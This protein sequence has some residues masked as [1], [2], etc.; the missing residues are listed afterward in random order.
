MFN[1]QKSTKKL[2][3]PNVS[4]PLGR[5]EKAITGAGM[6]GGTEWERE[7]EKY[8]ENTMAPYLPGWAT[9]F[10]HPHQDEGHICLPSPPLCLS[11]IIFFPCYPKEESNQLPTRSWQIAT[12]TVFLEMPTGSHPYNTTEILMKA[13]S[14]LLT[15]LMEGLEP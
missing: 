6:E 8:T 13:D 11:F 2:K 7:G 14:P 5:V 10:A 12:G 3:S 4:I 15:L 1:P 9:Y